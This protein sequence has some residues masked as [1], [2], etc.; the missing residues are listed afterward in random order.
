MHDLIVLEFEPPI[1]LCAD[2]AEPAWDSL[3]HSFSVLPLHVL[4]L[5]QSKYVNIKKIKTKVTQEVV[6]VKETMLY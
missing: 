5:F 3:S 6:G 1:E 4:F 2:S